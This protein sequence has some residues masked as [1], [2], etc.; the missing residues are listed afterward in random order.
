MGDSQGGVTDGQMFQTST[1]RPNKPQWPPQVPQPGVAHTY[2]VD[3]FFL[4]N[5]F[6]CAVRAQRTGGG[7]E[8]REEQVDKRTEWIPLSS[9]AVELSIYG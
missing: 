3:P 9:G 7:G 4:F 6:Y 2:Y 1:S 5:F 8:E